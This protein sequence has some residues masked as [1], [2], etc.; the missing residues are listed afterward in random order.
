MRFKQQVSLRRV[1]LKVTRFID[2]DLSMYP[3]FASSLFRR[4]GR[5]VWFKELGHGAGSTI[6]SLGGRVCCLGNA[7]T[8]RLLS[9]WSGAWFEP[10]NFLN[11][12]DGVHALNI[13]EKLMSSYTGLRLVVSSPDPLKILT[14]V[15]L[16]RRTD[17]H[18][19]V[20]RWVKKVFSTHPNAATLRLLGGSLNT[21][22]SSFQVRQLAEVIRDVEEVAALSLSIDPW[23]LRERLL[24]IKYVGPKVA[25]AFLLFTGKGTVFTPAD[26]HYQRLLR[27]LGL[28]P[29][30]RIPSK[31]VC[32]KYGPEC[33]SCRLSGNCITGLSISM[34]GRLSGFIQTLSYVHDK[35][36]CG[37]AQCNTCRLRGFCS[38][39]PSPRGLST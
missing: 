1:C 11:D 34:F 21:L 28:I 29:R 8:P 25:D 15:F 19:N 36:V 20:V 26:T 35:L 4:L 7:C 30:A 14:A 3:S 2:L 33:T 23:K 10:W 22:S 5:N 9:E 31:D 39:P 16:S 12:I 27:R 13:A 17:Y 32:L 18:G 37:K 24:Y 6:S 38:T